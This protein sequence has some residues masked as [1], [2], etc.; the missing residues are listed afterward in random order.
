[1]VSEGLVS[2]RR[3]S[4]RGESRLVELEEVARSQG[5]VRER[6]RESLI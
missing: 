1:M 5:K 4:I 6:E 2:V 3:E